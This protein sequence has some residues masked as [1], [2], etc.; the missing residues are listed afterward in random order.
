MAEGMRCTHTTKWHYLNY[1]ICYFLEFIYP[2]T[3]LTFAFIIIVILTMPSSLAFARDIK[4]IVPHMQQIFTFATLPLTQ[5]LTGTHTE[6]SHA[7]K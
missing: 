2:F 6:H 5:T 4:I 3:L 1:S 7:A